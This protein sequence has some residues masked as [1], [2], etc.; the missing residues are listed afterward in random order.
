MPEPSREIEITA[1]EADQRLDRYL[2]KLLR[3]VPLGA[4]FKHLRAGR[5]RIDGK[6]CKPELR[7]AAGMR[8]ELRLPAADIATGRR[9]ASQAQAPAKIIGRSYARIRIVYRCD[10]VLVVDKPAGVTVQGGAPGDDSVVGWLDHKRYGV[11]TATFAPA[12]AHRLDRETSGLLAIGLSPRGLRGLTA[13]FRDGA[14]DKIYVAVTEGCPVDPAGSI[15]V[16]LLEVEAA[17]RDQPKV[18]AGMAG[19]PARTD[20]RVLR[21]RD[22][23]ALLQLQREQLAPLR[24]RVVTVRFDDVSSVVYGW[25]PVLAYAPRHRLGKRVLGGWQH[26]ASAFINTRCGNNVAVGVAGCFA[27]IGD[28]AYFVTILIQEYCSNFA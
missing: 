14:V 4:I 12:P 7:L 11:R 10:D 9:R 13:A 21:G 25:E 26:D 2:R 1:S 15:D 28:Y 17:R 27:G 16:P 8:I 24:Q 23:L 19:R 20:Y 6:K 18:R 22:E 5:I 3:E